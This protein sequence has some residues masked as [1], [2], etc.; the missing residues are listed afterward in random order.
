[1]PQ[2]TPPMDTPDVLRG[3]NDTLLNVH[4]KDLDQLT[5][6]DLDIALGTCRSQLDL[7]ITFFEVLTRSK[8][9]HE[10][11]PRLR[12]WAG[13]HDAIHTSRQ[14]V[15]DELDVGGYYDSRNDTIVVAD[16]DLAVLFHE[17]GHQLQTLGVL[18]RSKK[19]DAEVAA[20]IFMA[21]VMHGLNLPLHPLYHFGPSPHLSRIAYSAARF[22]CGGRLE[23]CEPFFMALREGDADFFSIE[24]FK[25]PPYDWPAIIPALEDYLNNP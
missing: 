20:N 1:M 13:V 25:T 4:W 16:H 12:F 21:S 19:L 3:T 8:V 2:I 5:G 15:N 9:S 18:N 22:H 14:L 17:Y 24:G 7:E 11:W 6:N 10:H 23:A